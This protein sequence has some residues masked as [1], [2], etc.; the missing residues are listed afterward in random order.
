MR[1]S[2]LAPLV[3]VVVTAV[4]CNAITGLGDDF[5][6][7]PPDGGGSD[8]GVSPSDAAIVD[9]GSNAVDS[10]VD[11]D[12]AAA[13][14]AF[15]CDADAGSNVVLCND[16]ETDAAWNGSELVDGTITFDL[17]AGPGG[18]RA[19]HA[20]VSSASTSRRAALWG[21]VA[22]AD[23][24]SFAHYDVAFDFMVA[25]K[26]INYAAVGVLAVPQN[27]GGNLP[28]Y[29]LASFSDKTLDVVDDQPRIVPDG[30][31]LVDTYGTWHHAKMTFDRNGGGTYDVTLVV[32][33]TNID[34]PRTLDFG[35]AATAE[36][37]IGIL[38]TST[39]SGEMDLF[40]DNV[41]ARRTP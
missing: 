13:S 17:D 28:Y 21:R 10:A 11:A 6:L 36:V 22:G 15:T 34:V 5:V 4:A 16:F 8:V 39:D 19:M 37:R 23:A 20:H 29:G 30:I 40:V 9:D 7:A 32:D 33:A 1:C 41:L 3:A 2:K 24:K 12:A 14:D 26:T 27:P 31:G 25:S 35:D 18:T 38:F